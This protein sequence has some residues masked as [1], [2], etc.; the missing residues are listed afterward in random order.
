VNFT[1]AQVNVALE[2]YFRTLAGVLPGSAAL[3]WDRVGGSYTVDDSRLVR[4]L[5][6]A[7][8]HGGPLRYCNDKQIE[9]LGL[10]TTGRVYTP[11]KM[12]GEWGGIPLEGMTRRPSG[13]EIAQH[14][15]LTFNQYRRV[16]TSARKQVKR[17]M[18]ED[19]VKR[20]GQRAQLA[21]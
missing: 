20:I 4:F 11:G 7:S 5:D 21:S 17:A 14:M 10:L 13:K 1:T 8:R 12:G 6:L 16:I 15:G 19:L 3:L 9:A 18:S 2:A